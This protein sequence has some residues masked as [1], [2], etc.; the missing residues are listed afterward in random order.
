MLPHPETNAPCFQVDFYPTPESEDTETM[1]VTPA[2][3]TSKYLSKLKQTAETVIGKYV[4]GTVISVSLDFN[5]D[6][7][8]ALIEATQ[9]A[10]FKYVYV[11][12]EP[13]AAGKLVLISSIGV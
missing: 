6:A 7:Q 13:I 9:D 2:S 1:L 8:K 12:K 3:I 4:Q 11:I 10:G 5:Q